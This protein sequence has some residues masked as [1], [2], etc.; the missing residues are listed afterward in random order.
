[1]QA[2][3]SVWACLT[4]SDWLSNYISTHLIHTLIL[5]LTCAFILSQLQPS[6]TVALIGVRQRRAAMAAASIVNMT[7]CYLCMRRHREKEK[8]KNTTVSVQHWLVRHMRTSHII[9]VPLQ[10]CPSSSSTRPGPHS[11]RLEPLVFTHTSAQPPLAFSH[12]F[13]SEHRTHTPQLGQILLSDES[14]FNRLSTRWVE[15]ITSRQ[16][17]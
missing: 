4:I 11:Q 12:S 10:L 6:G 14:W 7:A 5:T 2:C 16:F 1:M 9:D 13:T 15:F 17:T 3:I 8:M